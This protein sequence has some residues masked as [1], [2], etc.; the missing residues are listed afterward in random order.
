METRAYSHATSTS[1]VADKTD[2]ARVLKTWRKLS[3][4]AG[5]SLLSLSVTLTVLNII[6]TQAFALET[7]TEIHIIQEDTATTAETKQR[8]SDRKYPTLRR[9]D[10]GEDVGYLQRRLWEWGY[11]KQGVTNIFGPDTEKAVKRFQQDH[12]ILPNGVVN[13]QTWDAIEKRTNPTIPVPPRCNRPTLQPGSEGRDVQELQ[14]RLYDL[15]YL[16]IRPSGYFGE[17]TKKAVI[18]FQQERDLPAT[19][20]VNA[21]TWE[22]L[23]LSCKTKALFVVIV[24]VT[25]RYVLEDVRYYVTDAFI[26]RTEA[27]E[28]INAGE[29]PNQQ[30]AKKRADFLRGKGFDARFVRIGNTQG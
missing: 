8:R 5:L 17:A 13:A 27:G 22:A 12:D 14:Q 18:R 4:I 30:E 3:G 2:I 11:F 25:N 29:F 20:T 15:G 9:G 1:E 21:R 24:P 16:K 19:G 28:Y 10:R 23:R 7:T 26:F 6:A